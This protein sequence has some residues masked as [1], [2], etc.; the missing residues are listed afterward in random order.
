MLGYLLH[1]VRVHITY[2]KYEITN[3]LYIL[4]LYIIVSLNVNRNF[5]DAFVFLLLLLH[6][7][8]THIHIDNT[9]GS[10]TVY[11]K[12][13]L[14]LL[15]FSPLS[16]HTHTRNTLTHTYTHT[17]TITHKPQARA[18]SKPVP[19]SEDKTITHGAHQR[20]TKRWA[21]YQW[22]HR[23]H[24][25]DTTRRNRM[26]TFERAWRMSW[27]WTANCVDECFDILSHCQPNSYLGHLSCIPKSVGD[28]AWLLQYDLRFE[29][30]KSFNSNPSK[31]TQ[32]SKKSDISVVCVRA[33]S[34]LERK[35]VND[36]WLIS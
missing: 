10:G 2:N 27:V 15:V 13:L 23:F 7:S 20:P 25:Q 12:L 35:D 34:H 22:L 4:I 29:P 31:T 18:Q 16:T 3:E 26:Q 32:K 5:S 19:E 8:S 6:T 33:F 17:H 28:L 1:P 9:L 30:D 14:S 21:Q 24:E 11:Q 36:I